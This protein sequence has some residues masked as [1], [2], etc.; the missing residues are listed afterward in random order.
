MLLDP[1]CNEGEHYAREQEYNNEECS[2]WLMGL[3][4]LKGVE[5]GRDDEIKKR[6]TKDVKRR[7]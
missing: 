7:R 5:G 2:T 4:M 3:W 6:I 1:I